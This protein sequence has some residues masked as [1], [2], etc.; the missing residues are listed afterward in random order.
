[1]T[2]DSATAFPRLV[3]LVGSKREVSMQKILK[4]MLGLVLALGFAAMIAGA[5]A[6]NTAQTSSAADCTELPAVAAKLERADKILHDWPNLARYGESNTKIAAPA[7]SERRVVFMGDSITDSWVSPEFGGFFPGKAYIDRGIS[8][9]TT[10][11]MLIR[12][13][14]DVIAL[15]PKVVVITGR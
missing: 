10:P 1:L 7:K 4:R 14:P 15:Q 9:Q 6:P 13:R 3:F 11:Q 5:Q 8:G 12:F 2:V